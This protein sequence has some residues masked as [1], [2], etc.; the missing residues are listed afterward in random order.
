[1]INLGFF[2]R[3]FVNQTPLLLR[4][5]KYR[6]CVVPRTQNSFGDLVTRLAVARIA[7]TRAISER[8][9]FPKKRLSTRT[10]HFKWHHKNLSKMTMSPWKRIMSEDAHGLF[11]CFNTKN[12]Q[13]YQNL[14]LATQMEHNQSSYFLPGPDDFCWGP[15]LVGPTLMTGS[16]FRRQRLFCCRTQ[17]LERSATG[18]ATRRHR[19]LDNSETCWN[20]ISL[21]FSQPRRI[22]TFW[23]LRLRS[24]FT[25]LLT[26]LLTLAVIQVNTTFGRYEQVHRQCMYICK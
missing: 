9:C 2:V 16:Q 5:A 19:P 6:T 11:R 20:R 17:N 18:T 1:M 4:S 23:L 26:Y 24:T 14:Y 13:I 21:G 15:A 10:M 22:V 12:A 7:Y 8:R 25:Y 3:F